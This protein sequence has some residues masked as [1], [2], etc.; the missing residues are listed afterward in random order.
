LRINIASHRSNIRNSVSH[1]FTISVI[2]G[3]S[4]SNDVTGA[5]QSLL[6]RRVEKA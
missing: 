1:G 6:I 3:L 4:H 5:P 2:D